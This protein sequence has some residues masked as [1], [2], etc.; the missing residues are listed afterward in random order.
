LTDEKDEEHR[1]EHERE[2][3]ITNPGHVAH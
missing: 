1:H 3:A 2:R